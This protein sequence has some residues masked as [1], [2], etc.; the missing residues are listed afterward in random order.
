[1]NRNDRIKGLTQV[2][3]VGTVRVQV[4]GHQFREQIGGIHH[5]FLG[6]LK[7][8][9]FHL[10]EEIARELIETGRDEADD[11]EQ[12]GPGEARGY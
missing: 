6:G 9:R 2:G 12:G 8:L 4:R 3:R 10:R 11:K 7:C 5:H 1:L